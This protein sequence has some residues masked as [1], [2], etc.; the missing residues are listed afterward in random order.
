MISPPLC[1]Q[2]RAH[3]GEEMTRDFRLHVADRRSRKIDGDVSRLARRRR[4]LERLQVVG[5]DRQDFERGHFAAQRFGRFRQA[6]L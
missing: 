1:P 4:Q 6:L 2:S 3:P 5:A